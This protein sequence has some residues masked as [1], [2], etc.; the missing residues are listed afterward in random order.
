[1]IKMKGLG[2]G[3][4]ALLTGNDKPHGDEQRSLPIERL[5]TGRVAIEL[6]G[7]PR[8][9]AGAELQLR[10]LLGAAGIR[11]DAWARVAAPGAGVRVRFTI[12]P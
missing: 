8:L 3:L 10:Q 5:R 2:R 9:L 11:V 12:Q 1:M 6:A 4:D 7:S